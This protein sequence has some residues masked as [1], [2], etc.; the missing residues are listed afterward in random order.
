MQI[1]LGLQKHPGISFYAT[2]NR[3]TLRLHKD[4]S[5]DSSCTPDKGSVIDGTSLALSLV[6]LC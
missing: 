4:R 1:V 3:L 2:R 5:L 6:L